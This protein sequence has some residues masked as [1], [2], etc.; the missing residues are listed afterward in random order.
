MEPPL[1]LAGVSCR[2]AS[3]PELPGSAWTRCCPAAALLLPRCTLWLPRAAGAERVSLT[4][5][6]EAQ[7]LRHQANALAAARCLQL[8][9]LSSANSSCKVPVLPPGWEKSKERGKVRAHEICY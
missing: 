7:E 5:G 6:R 1:D 9:G 8:A 3:T 2:G 4:F